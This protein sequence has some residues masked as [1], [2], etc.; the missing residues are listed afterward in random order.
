M[1]DETGDRRREGEPQYR[2]AF[3]SSFALRG[4]RILR[5]GFWVRALQALL[6]ATRAV[7]CTV[8]SN[9]ASAKVVA[10][11]SNHTDM[12]EAVILAYGAAG[13]EYLVMF[14]SPH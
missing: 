3:A 2:C 8:S 11:L 9:G 13:G 4:A 5:Q 12:A 6:G 1:F 14:R 10:G 7:L